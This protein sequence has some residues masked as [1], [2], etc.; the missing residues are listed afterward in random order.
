MP[1]NGKF[2]PNYLILFPRSIRL[3]L[4][5]QL[6][7]PW[8]G[9]GA[10]RY[11][12]EDTLF[13]LLQTSTRKVR[14]RL[15]KMAQPLLFILDRIATILL[16][17]D[18]FPDCLDSSSL[19]GIDMKSFLYAIF[20]ILVL[21]IAISIHKPS[22]VERPGTR[23]QVSDSQEATVERSGSRTQLTDTQQSRPLGRI[24]SSDHKDESVEL[25]GVHDDTL[26]PSNSP[27]KQKG[28]VE[29]PGTASMNELLNAMEGDDYDNG[30]L[31]DWQS[32]VKKASRP[33]T[34]DE[35]HMR[36]RTP[37]DLPAK[38][39]TE[40][41]ST[42]P[43]GELSWPTS[44]DIEEEKDL[45]IEGFETEESFGDPETW[46]GDGGDWAPK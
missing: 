21:V 43:E 44:D 24:Q 18:P 42:A 27:D 11:L 3:A 4:S 1:K 7:N 28:L 5:R 16:F 46:Q 2:L 9:C 19:E 8:A 17:L 22:D 14:R 37:S 20:C 39:W 40:P 29:G 30:W 33:K 36:R 25:G 34:R 10:N 26:R 31:W 13:S 41:K 32:A 45:S 35:G 38:Q 12:I 6:T 15:E 23:S